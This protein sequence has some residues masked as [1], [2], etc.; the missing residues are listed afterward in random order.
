M[1]LQSTIRLYCAADFMGP[2]AV[3]VPAYSVKKKKLK[4]GGPGSGRHPEGGSKKEW[5]ERIKRLDKMHYDFK[6]DSARVTNESW[7]RNFGQA[8]MAVASMLREVKSWPKFDDSGVRRTDTINFRLRDAEGCLTRASQQHNIGS[9]DAATSLLETAVG[10]LHVI[11]RI[12]NEEVLHN[13]ITIRGGGPGSGRRPEAGTFQGWQRPQT[14]LYLWK[15]KK[16]TVVRRALDDGKE[17]V[18]EYDK[19]KGL[20]QRRAFDNSESTVKHLSDRYGIRAVTVKRIV[21][22]AP[23]DGPEIYET[24]NR[25]GEILQQYRDKHGADI[26]KEA[27]DRKRFGLGKGYQALRTAKGLRDGI[28]IILDA[29]KQRRTTAGTGGT[30][31]PGNG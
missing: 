9:H 23:V 24:R 29:D 14:G 4:A 28:I 22:P 5:T 2:S 11:A 26:A 12:A 18:L 17:E 31:G 8:R 10:D 19:K 6:E 1:N 20:T 16:S 7:I 25:R 15:G 3:L 30:G 13:K 27:D 21:N